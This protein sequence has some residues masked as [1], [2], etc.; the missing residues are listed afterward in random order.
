[1]LEGVLVSF[2]HYDLKL[3]IPK[4]KVLILRIYS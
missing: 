2:G 3:P 1:M 4:I